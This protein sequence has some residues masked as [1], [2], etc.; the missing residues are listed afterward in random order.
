MQ[1]ILH[2]TCGHAI[3]GDTPAESLLACFPFRNAP[4]RSE[5]PVQTAFVWRPSLAHHLSHNA[6]N[7]HIGE[8][9][10]NER[11]SRSHTLFRMVCCLATSAL[12][13]L[14]VPRTSSWPVNDSGLSRGTRY[15]APQGIHLLPSL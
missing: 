1:A 6:A 8:T 2:L 10:M 11:S 5:Y 4:N 15:G 13:R 3:L 9:N 12:E 7:R 14:L